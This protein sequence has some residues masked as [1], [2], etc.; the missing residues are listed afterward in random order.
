MIQSKPFFV[1]IIQPPEDRS[2]LTQL[3]HVIYS[4]FGLV[5]VTILVVAAAGL[6]I[7]SVLF[8]VRKRSA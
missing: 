1:K 3:A 5:G 6:V 4:V 7:G 2:G 8:W